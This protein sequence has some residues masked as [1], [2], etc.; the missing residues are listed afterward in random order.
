MVGTN[1]TQFSQEDSAYRQSIVDQS[2]KFAR[3]MSAAL[4]YCCINDATNI[5]EAFL[6][7]LSKIFHFNPNIIENKTDV[8]KPIFDL[9]NANFSPSLNDRNSSNKSPRQQGVNPRSIPS[10]INISPTTFN[11]S[12]VGTNF[13]S[14]ARSAAAMAAVQQI[15]QRLGKIKHNLNRTPTNTQTNGMRDSVCQI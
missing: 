11:Y 3:R 7:I 14:T 4:M 15:Q 2:R 5:H 8:D 9:S 10:N 6:Y 13:P 1:Y 12:R